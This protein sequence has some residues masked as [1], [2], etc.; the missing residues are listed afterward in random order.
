M[1][2]SKQSNVFLPAYLPDLGTKNLHISSH[3]WLLAF[4]EQI[5]RLLAATLV[6]TTLLVATCVTIALL[7]TTWLAD[8]LVVERFAH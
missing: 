1:H 6:T 3:D 2:A 5:V 7:V 4:M 8:A